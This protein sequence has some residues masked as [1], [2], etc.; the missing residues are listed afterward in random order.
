MPT[1]LEWTFGALVL[2]YVGYS[3]WAR[4]DARYPLIGGTFLAIV[5]GVASWRGE[6]GLAIDLAK[7]ATILFGG[8]VLLLLIDTAWVRARVA[9][10]LSVTRGKVSGD[11]T[12]S[13]QRAADHPLDRLQ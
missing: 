13:G 8:G 12:G 1:L 4:L 9:R 5:A 3:W 7:Y 11:P 10:I 6:L 2:G